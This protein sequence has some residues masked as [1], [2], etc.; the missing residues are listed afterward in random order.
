MQ[1][2][3]VGRQLDPAAAELTGPSL[4]FSLSGAGYK[5]L[6]AGCGQKVTLLALLGSDPDLRDTLDSGS[7]GSP[8]WGRNVTHP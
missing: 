1:Q 5:S 2:L 8:G 7:H 6:S 4:I 3:A